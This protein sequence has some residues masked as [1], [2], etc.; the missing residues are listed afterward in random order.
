MKVLKF[1]AILFLCILLSSA[2]K[3]DN[4]SINP[5]FLGKYYGF[6]TYETE[7]NSKSNANGFVEIQKYGNNY[8][9]VFSDEI[10]TLTNIS[11]YQTENTITLMDDN[12]SNILVITPTKMTIY[13]TKNNATWKANCSR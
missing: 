11:I 4:T 3:D 9:Y 6:V 13:Y 10:P 1:T 7:G 2:C 12:K 8:K 5:N